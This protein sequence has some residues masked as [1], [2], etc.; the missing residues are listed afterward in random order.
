MSFNQAS[1][2]RKS[3]MAIP[4]TKGAQGASDQVLSQAHCKPNPE[5]KR[6]PG[7]PSCSKG[8]RYL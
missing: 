2:L 7:S 1:D 6:P 4:S 3:V 8:G 5:R